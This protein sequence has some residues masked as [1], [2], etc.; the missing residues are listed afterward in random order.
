MKVLD[1]IVGELKAALADKGKEIKAAGSSAIKP[2]TDA[3][4]VRQREVISFETSTINIKDESGV[5]LAMV[6]RY[7]RDARELLVMIQQLKV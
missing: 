4:M 7:K 6:E 3:F 1:A 5:T 2:V